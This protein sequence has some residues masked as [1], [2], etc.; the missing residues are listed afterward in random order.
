MIVI[1]AEGGGIR[2]AYWTGRAME[3]ISDTGCFGTAVLAASGVSGGSVGL[4]LT[5]L[6]S[7]E[8]IG[9]RLDKLARPETLA[10]AASGLLVGESSLRSM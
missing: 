5:D 4:M 7:S 6:D 3:E 9:E 10:T 2:A 8:T 1:A